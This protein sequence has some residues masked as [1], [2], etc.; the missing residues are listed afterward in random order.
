M[1]KA[2]PHRGLR[3]LFDVLIVL[4]VPAVLAFAYTTMNK[5][6]GTAAAAPVTAPRA[7]PAAPTTAGR[8]QVAL[9]VGNA[10]AWT[11]RDGTTLVALTTGDCVAGVTPAGR[12][13]VRRAGATAFSQWSTLPL[14]EV[15][16]ID[17]VSAGTVHVSGLD[18][19]CRRINGVTTDGGRTWA[20][21]TGF[22][23]LDRVDHVDATV[24]WGIGGGDHSQVVRT[25]DGGRTFEPVSFPCPA[26]V[27]APRLVTAVSADA[28]WVVCAGPHRRGQ[29]AR[30]L[31]GTADGGASWTELAGARRTAARAGGP[32]G[33]DG[34][35][36]LRAVGFSSVRDGWAGVA[37]PTCGVGELRVTA[38]SGRTWQRLACPT[39]HGV[40]LDRAFA[41]SFR[42][43]TRGIVVGVRDGVAAA[44]ETTDGGRT[45]RA[46]AGK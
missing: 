1:P 9:P 5:T 6:P 43:A 3:R 15:E 11:G 42:D 31:Y 45:W 33:L 12:I 17:R 40:A 23:K 46:V 35:G 36:E 21:A 34:D 27:A 37:T 10:A 32:D 25:R 22:D 28:A 26:D 2:D 24:A 14:A 30:L 29:Q 8:D 4:L 16:S 19:Q 7:T 18:A 20:R 39:S 13:D 38:D 44:F 41:T